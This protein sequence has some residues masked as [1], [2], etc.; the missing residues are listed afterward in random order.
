MIGAHG[1]RNAQ[2]FLIP[3]PSSQL[4]VLSLILVSNYPLVSRVVSLSEC[5]GQQ[6]S[7]G[8]VS[9]TTPQKL[10]VI[11]SARRRSSW[12]PARCQRLGMGQLHRHSVLPTPP[13]PFQTLLSFAH[14]LLSRQESFCCFPITLGPVPV[15]LVFAGLHIC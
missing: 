5:Y 3:H 13:G 6:C 14:S 11:D 10:I 8:N 15:R 9:L 7:G 4:R 1:G 2:R 12:T